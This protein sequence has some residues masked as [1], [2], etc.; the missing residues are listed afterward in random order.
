MERQKVN[1]KQEK[2]SS[3][4]SLCVGAV[5]HVSWMSICGSRPVHFGVRCFD[6]AVMD[7]ME[8]S[9]R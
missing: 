9:G 7:V 8:E 3:L 2:R 5:K 1:F 6:Q 4:F